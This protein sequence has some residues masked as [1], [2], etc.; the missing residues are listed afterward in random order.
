MSAQAS[1]RRVG[2]RALRSAPAAAAAVAVALALCAASL[3]AQ[4]PPADEF[5]RLEPV[6]QQALA[7]AAPFT[8]TIET[9]G[10]TRQV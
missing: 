3:T 9:F 7:A 8:V 2:A 10:G 5:V 6:V 4:A 1:D